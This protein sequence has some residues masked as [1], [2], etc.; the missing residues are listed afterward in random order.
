MK[1]TL[2]CLIFF[3]L[4]IGC[5][6]IPV[7]AQ[8]QPIKIIVNNKL[9]YS[10]VP[11]KIVSGRTLVPVRVISESLGARVQWN[12][13][14]QQAI[15]LKGNLSIVL[16]KE[17]RIYMLNGSRKE[18]DVPVKIFQN[19]VFV[20]LRVI[21]EAFGNKVSWDDVD[22]IVYVTETKGSDKINDIKV[23]NGILTVTNKAAVI[24]EGN[25]ESSKAL[26][27]N[28][29]GNRF[30]IT[31]KKGEWYRINLPTG[32]PGWIK[33]SYITLGSIN[34]P[35][36]GD[37]E[38]KKQVT[39]IEVTE[40]IV[41]VRKGPGI[42]FD[43]ITQVELGDVFLSYEK[44]DNWYKIRLNDK[45]VGW[46]SGELVAE[47]SKDPSEVVVKE[48]YRMLLKKIKE[49]Y[50]QTSISFNVGIEAKVR[51]LKNSN[52]EL[53]LTLEGVNFDESLL[54]QIQIK[55]PFQSLKLNQISD[56][57]VRIDTIVT[58]GGYFRLD[59]NNDEFSITAVKR[60]KNG[61]KGL[62]GKTI[63]IS[64][65]HGNYINGKVD[66]GAIGQKL[67]LSE[68][69]F[70]TPVSIKLKNK[71]TQAGAKVIMVREK[72]PVYTTL[73]Q[74]AMIANNNSADAFI[75]IHGD[76]SPSNPNAK[77]IGVYIYDGDLRLTSVAQKDI[78]NEFAQIIL[79]ELIKS[80]SSN[81]SVKVGNFAVLRENEV[82]SV[83]IECGFLSTPEEEYLLSTEAYQEKL[84]EGMY[85]GIK[86]WFER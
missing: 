7:Q 83:L 24:Y 38:N 14:L 2:C 81:G 11:P 18:L 69:D 39:S 47:S 50:G 86:A 67:R 33:D 27:K 77:G 51:V 73:Y 4:F 42:K 58:N 6:S 26:L 34:L 79:S 80:T 71:L 60:N 21:G 49:G 23:M 75:S 66:P 1:K 17:N 68:V 32:M 12:Q 22:R 63:V 3:I 46:I 8:S 70:N 41:N 64:P 16:T 9:V 48:P 31:G 84:A 15:I 55:D 53:S 52:N 62:V 35:N 19:R 82:P 45:Q 72:D 30:D 76:S 5:M 57:K 85:R 56:S 25:S 40:A 61:V 44:T 29:K 36:D 78:R 43:I 10:D 65:G 37:N 13:G 28:I 59:R 20:P 74:R 54:K